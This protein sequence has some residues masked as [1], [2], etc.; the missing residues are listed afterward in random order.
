MIEQIVINVVA[1]CLIGTVIWAAD[2]Y[3]KIPEP[4]GWVKGILIFVLIVAACYFMW[5]HFV[6][7]GHLGRGRGW[8]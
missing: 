1:L 6:A 7:G 4:F 5:D 8:R 2:K 3:L